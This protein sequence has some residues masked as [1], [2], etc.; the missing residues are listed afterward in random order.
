MG[1]LIQRERVR[2]L[3]DTISNN[4]PGN[5]IEIFLDKYRNVLSAALIT[6]GRDDVF[7]IPIIGWRP[8]FLTYIQTPRG[9]GVVVPA[10][11]APAASLGAREQQ[12]GA[13]QR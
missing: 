1:S 8:P 5:L 11:P 13:V 12:L 10:S 6:L 9:R 4:T 3:A 2:S 7:L